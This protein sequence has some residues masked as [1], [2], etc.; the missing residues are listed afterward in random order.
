M[1]VELQLFEHESVCQTILGDYKVCLPFSDN[2][3]YL[4]A[5]KLYVEWEDKSKI[6][7]KIFF[8]TTE[9]AQSFIK[10]TRITR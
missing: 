8:N 5:D 7:H 2:Y 6:K 9:A 3:K 1:F 4:L 10:S